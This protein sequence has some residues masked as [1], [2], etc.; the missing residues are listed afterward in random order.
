M[1]DS[2]PGNHYIPYN[3]ALMIE[4]LGIDQSA[5]W[6]VHIIGRNP[7]DQ[8]QCARAFYVNFS[9]GAQ[10]KDAC[11]LS[12]GFDLFTHGF[13]IRW[14]NPPPPFPLIFAGSAPG[15]GRFKIVNPLPTV[16]LTKYGAQIL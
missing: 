16:F 5:D 7:L 14:F 10:I 1:V 13:K 6:P 15:S 3:P 9:E 11:P 2:K 8:C 4:K 12:D